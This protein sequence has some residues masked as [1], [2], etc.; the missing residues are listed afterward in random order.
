MC[1]GVK[2]KD[3][4]KNIVI[5]KYSVKLKKSEDNNNIKECIICYYNDLH[6]SMNNCNH[7]VCYNCFCNIVCC[8]LCRL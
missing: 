3:L 6:I 4:T 8:P 1:K 2:L 5:N 7:E